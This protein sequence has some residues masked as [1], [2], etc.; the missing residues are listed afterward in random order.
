MPIILSNSAKF[1]LWQ[2]KLEG[3]EPFR[4]TTMR[5]CESAYRVLHGEVVDGEW[6]VFN[7][8][9]G[10]E[11][12]FIAGTLPKIEDVWAVCIQGSVFDS[13][14]YMYGVCAFNDLWQEI[15]ECWYLSQPEDAD[16]IYC[17][18]QFFSRNPQAFASWI[19]DHVIQM[20]R[21]IYERHDF[22][23]HVA[24]ACTVLIGDMLNAGVSPSFIFGTIAKAEEL[25]RFISLLNN[26]KDILL[27]ESVRAAFC[28]DYSEAK[29]IRSKVDD[30]LDSELLRCKKYIADS[31]KRCIPNISIHSADR[32]FNRG[33]RELV[34]D[35]WNQTNQNF[36]TYFSVSPG[37]KV[38]FSRSVFP[39]VVQV[40]FKAHESYFLSVRS[41]KRLHGLDFA[42]I[43]VARQLINQIAQK[44]K[45]TAGCLVSDIGKDCTWFISEEDWNVQGWDRL[46]T[47]YGF[48]NHSDCTVRVGGK[49]SFVVEKDA[50]ELMLHAW[51][52]MPWS[53]GEYPVAV[54][55][56]TEFSEFTTGVSSV[57]YKLNVL[58]PSGIHLL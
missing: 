22:K 18:H 2:Q 30:F 47:R 8:A 46:K 21:T 11:T 37:V 1:K 57:Y 7:G 29:S 49:Q 50:A 5:H 26:K 16:A 17:D 14:A 4:V 39:D 27:R 48:D 43:E 25:E 56:F 53:G 20:D 55:G 36:W 44:L 12:Q 9:F 38:S 13:I 35:A 6:A 42:G 45:A 34:Y 28:W 54:Y 40:G 23:V 32:D 3:V 52:F 58:N 15:R 31:L 10:E 33:D 24:A 51:E 19:S 41:G